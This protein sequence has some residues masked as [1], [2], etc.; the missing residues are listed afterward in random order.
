LNTRSKSESTL[1]IAV[2][3]SRDF[4]SWER[5]TSRSIKGE[6]EYIKSSPAIWAEE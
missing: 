5:R 4:L 3:L 1:R 6:G 2:S